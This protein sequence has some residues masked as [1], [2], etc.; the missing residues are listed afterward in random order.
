MVDQTITK[1]IR[2]I[3][4]LKIHIHG[5]PYIITFTLMKNNVLDSSSSMLLSWPWLCNTCVIHDWG[6]NLITIEG[7]G[8]VWII[9]VTK[10][11]DNNTRC[12]KVLLC[13]NLMEGVTY[14]KEEIL[15]TTKPNLFTLRTITLHEPE[16]LNVVIFGAKAS[17]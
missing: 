15:L 8:M 9:V 6:N 16:I 2:F 5:I 10:D 1:P 17:T 4:D 7:N 12:P 13:Y 3:K 14:E 11:L